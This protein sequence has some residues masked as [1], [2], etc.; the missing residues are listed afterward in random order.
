MGSLLVQNITGYLPS[1]KQ[2]YPAMVMGVKGNSRSNADI[3]T[4][5]QYD[6]LP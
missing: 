1:W 2:Y 5:D 4:E 3:A 6:N